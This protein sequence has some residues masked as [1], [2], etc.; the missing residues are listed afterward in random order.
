MAH[1]RKMAREDGIDK[2]MSDHNVDLIVVPGDSPI[3]SLTT[4]AG[5]LIVPQEKTHMLISEAYPIAAVPNGVLS[6]NGRPHGLSLVTSV[7]NTGKLLEFM[8]I[9]EKTFPKRP[10]PSMLREKAS[11]L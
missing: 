10:I 2:A 6:L 1:I 9:F 8:S 4:C 3:S 7:V 11:S 5:M